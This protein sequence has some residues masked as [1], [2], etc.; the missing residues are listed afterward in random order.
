M[1]E[2]IWHGEFLVKDIYGNIIYELRSSNPL[3]ICH[4]VCWS[5]PKIVPNGKISSAVEWESKQDSII[6]CDFGGYCFGPS[7]NSKR[8][9]M[10]A[11]YFIKQPE[12]ISDINKGVTF[13]NFMPH[14]YSTDLEIL[15]ATLKTIQLI[16]VD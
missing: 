6:N 2:I 8:V 12:D 9:Y 11:Y 14:H 3:T 13:E 1:H 7:S 16:K 5:I 4:Y 10:P 15:D